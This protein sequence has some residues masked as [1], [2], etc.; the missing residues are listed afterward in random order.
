[1]SNE[2]AATKYINAGTLVISTTAFGSIFFLTTAPLWGAAA[3]TTTIGG[4]A[5]ALMEYF[6]SADYLRTYTAEGLLTEYRESK[7]N[8]NFLECII[9]LCAETFW[10]NVSLFDLSFLTLS[11]ATVPSPQSFSEVDDLWSYNL[12]R[13][14]VV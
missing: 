13:K 7:K 1:M 5:K 10:V 2:A 4:G 3:A 11:N 9:N 12:D 14:S 6:N 8:Q